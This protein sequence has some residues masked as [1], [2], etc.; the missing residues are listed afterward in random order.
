M[1]LLIDDIAENLKVLRGMLA[2][3]NYRMTFATSGEQGLD[4]ARSS[5]PSMI[6]LDLMMPE[7]DGL[8]VC[9][10]LKAS[11]ETVNIPVIFLTASSD[12]N[13]L[14]GVGG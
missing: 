2:P 10:L 14:T 8:E 3:L 11:P 1:L 13:S 7:M 4:R 6:L 5:Q 9:R 12:I